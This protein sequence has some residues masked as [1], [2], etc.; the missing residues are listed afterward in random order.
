MFPGFGLGWAIY[1]QKHQNVLWHGG[2]QHGA[3]SMIYWLPDERL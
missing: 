3:T 2:N 1:T